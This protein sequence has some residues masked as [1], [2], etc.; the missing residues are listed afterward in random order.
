[1]SSNKL[2]SRL[3]RDDARLLDPHLEAVD[4]PVR[5]QLH[6]AKRRVDYIYF[7]ERGVASIVANGSHPIE[8]GMV[9]RE[10]M[11]GTSV[12]LGDSE[13]VPYDIYMQVA[14]TG[15]QMP[16]DRL[17]DAI[18][19]SPTLHR[20]LLGYVHVFI[21]QATQTALANARGKIE[22]RLARWLL[23]VHDRIDGDEL[24]LTHEFLSVMLGVRRSGV[25]TALHE[26]ER[27]GLIESRRSFIAIMDREGL[28]ESCNGI[29]LRPEV[30]GRTVIS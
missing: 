1:V 5:K 19:K 28:E 17:R 25:T 21:I 23:M 29:Y 2:L 4:L 30:G 7:I 13:R 3:S 11:T 8:V 15:Q 22:E 16:A 20:I 26:L 9:G 6:V 27:K 18:A 12:L 24:T 14:G 10:G